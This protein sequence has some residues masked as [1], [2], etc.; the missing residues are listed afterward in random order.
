MATDVL[1]QPVQNSGAYNPQDYSFEKLHIVTNA[2]QVFYLKDLMVEFC[3]FEDIYRPIVSGYITIKDSEG[4]IEAFRLNGTETLEIQFSKTSNAPINNFNT[5]TFKL[6]KISERKPTGNL[7][8]ETYKLHFCSEEMLLSEQIKISKS[9]KGKAINYIINDILV[10]NLK[11]DPS[12]LYLESTYGVYDFIIPRLKPLEAISWLSTYARPTAAPMGADMLFFKTKFGFNFR[13]LQSMFTGNVYRTYKYQV[14]NLTETTF[15][16]KAS[17]VLKYEFVKVFDTLNEISAGTYA[18]KLISVDPLTRQYKVTVFDYDAFTSQ[19]GSSNPYGVLNKVQNRLGFTQNQAYDSVIKV[20]FGNADEKRDPFVKEAEAGAA[21]DIYIE[22]YVPS[23]TAQ[24]SLANYTVL[25]LTI[26]GDSSV[27]AGC[28]IAFNLYSLNKDNSAKDLDKFYSGN[29]LVTSVRHVIHPGGDFI[30]VLEIAKN[31]SPT[32]F[33][34][35]VSS[36]QADTI[37]NQG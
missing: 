10:N 29:Y 36:K 11:I 37:I 14:K 9:Y 7:M 23:R 17:T 1:A 32:Q 33:T 6:Y 35:G 28:V 15:E 30:T 4:Y 20:A 13:S 5:Q 2:G 26:P 18:N 27:I 24:L 21:Q 16:D 34:G 8:A 31:S 3:L 19:M 22:T 12:L 25:K